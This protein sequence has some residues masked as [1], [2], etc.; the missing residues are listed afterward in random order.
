MGYWKG[1]VYHN[2]YRRIEEY[3]FAGHIK[4]FKFLCAL[5]GP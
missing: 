1:D 4:N 5:S 2:F 3:I